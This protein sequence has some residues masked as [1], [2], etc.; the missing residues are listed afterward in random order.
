MI[1]TERFLL[2]PA[3]QA[4]SAVLGIAAACCATWA[5]GLWAHPAEPGPLLLAC[6]I[7]VLLSAL[8][9]IYSVITPNR[10]DFG[11]VMCISSLV[12]VALVPIVG[13]GLRDVAHIFFIG[14][15]EWLRTIPPE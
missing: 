13:F 5:S 2:H 7:V 10:T 4:I 6:A 1:S 12:V 14:L 15:D 11:I 3:T 8:F 9:S